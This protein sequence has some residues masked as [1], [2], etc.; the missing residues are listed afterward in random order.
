MTD[1]EQFDI[2][3][4]ETQ[5]PLD[6]GTGSPLAALD[7]VFAIGDVRVSVRVHSKAVRTANHGQLEPQEAKQAARGLLEV[8]L[9]KGWKPTDGDV[10][11]LD[12]VT[13]RSC[14]APRLGWSRR[15]RA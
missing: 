11:T 5:Q 12:D 13:M 3:F 15:F 1:R 7:Y 14:V 10:L 8:K 2:K 4:V 9:E 6:P